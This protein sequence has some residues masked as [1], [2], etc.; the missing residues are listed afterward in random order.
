M[1]GVNQARFPEALLHRR[2]KGENVRNFIGLRVDKLWITATGR[3]VT[4][5]S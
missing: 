1:Q 2:N 3:A 4:Q 5:P